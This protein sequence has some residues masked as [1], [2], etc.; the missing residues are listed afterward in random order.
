[1]PFML[2]NQSITDRV[3][4]PLYCPKVVLR[5]ELIYSTIILFIFPISLFVTF[6]SL[7]IKLALKFSLWFFNVMNA[8]TL[9]IGLGDRLG[10]HQSSCH[11]N[12]K[13][14]N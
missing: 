12:D 13:Y 3:F 6:I 5:S 1:M 8:C 11:Q 2:W 4:W 9:R 10:L 7:H 14:N